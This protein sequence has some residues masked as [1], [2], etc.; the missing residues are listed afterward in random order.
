M[1]SSLITRAPHEYAL[2][3]TDSKCRQN[4]GRTAPIPRED[5][6][7]I[8][9]QLRASPDQD[10][11]LDGRHVESNF[12]A[13]FTTIHELRRDPLAEHSDPLPLVTFY[14]PRRALDAVARRT[15]I[16]HRDL[17][18]SA[19]RWH[20]RSCR[21]ASASSLRPATAKPEEAASLFSGLCAPGA[22]CPRSNFQ[23]IIR[24][25]PKT[26][27]TE[28]AKLAA[29]KFLQIWS[30]PWPSINRSTR[31]SATSLS[32]REVDP[33]ADSCTPVADSARLSCPFGSRALCQSI[34]VRL[35]HLR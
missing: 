12:L 1:P 19:R 24:R 32:F 17:S 8:S 27:L 30:R 35:S 4:F 23:E 20:R 7:L 28:A 6:Y 14:L 2:A 18:P 16:S 22:Q 29:T 25:T 15:G 10:P 33:P 5:A 34:C 21:A 9:L 26:S 11:P 13:G 31:R 3:V